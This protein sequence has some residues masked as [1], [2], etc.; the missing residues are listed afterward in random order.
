[1]ILRTAFI[2]NS[3]STS[4]FGLG[5]YLENNDTLNTKLAYFLVDQLGI[6]RIKS[7]YS[8]I[9]KDLNR[10]EVEEFIASP[11][12]V[13]TDVLENWVRDWSRENGSRYEK[14]NVRSDQ[15]DDGV[16][17]YVEYPDIGVDDDGVFFIAK[18][19]NLREEISRIKFLTE[20]VE[21]KASIGHVE[22]CWYDG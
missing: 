19:D 10:K 13:L 21:G 18:P 5:T 16:Y 1:M 17:V 2:T 11:Y 14:I 9:D 15:W 4:F 20:Q 12:R 22:D 3:S 6:D 8:R 7:M